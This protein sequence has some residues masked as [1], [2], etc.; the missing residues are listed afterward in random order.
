[1]DDE[2]VDVPG[3]MGCDMNDTLKAQSTLDSL[4]SSVDTLVLDLVPLTEMD[5]YSR[6]QDSK[7]NLEDTREAVQ[8][9]KDAVDKHNKETGDNMK[10]PD[11]EEE[12]K[13]EDKALKK[14][15][16]KAAKKERDA[17]SRKFR[18]LRASLKAQLASFVEQAKGLAKQVPIQLGVISANPYTAASVPAVTLQLIATIDSL[19]CIAST[20][21][22]FSI[23]INIPLPKAFTE[24]I[25]KLGSLKIV[26]GGISDVTKISKDIMNS[27]ESLKSDI[28]EQKN[29]AKNAYNT[30]QA[31]KAWEKEHVGGKW[32]DLSSTEQNAIVEEWIKNNKD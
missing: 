29:I 9:Y 20:V 11:P 17:T 26:L 7:S 15:V 18:A 27:V 32:E 6:Y 19:L 28:E 16:K 4:M 3:I 12:T 21:V 1:M 8:E 23:F 25:N 2:I 31:K 22:S 13:K 5:A 30:E 10:S 14:A 24:A